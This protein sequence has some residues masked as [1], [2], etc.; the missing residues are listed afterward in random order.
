[1]GEGELQK[2]RSGELELLYKD[3]LDNIRLYKQQQFAITN[4]VI[5]LYGAIVALHERLLGGVVEPTCLE[6]SVL[7]SVSVLVLIVGSYLI[8][9]FH[10]NMVGCRK[11]MEKIR[12]SFEDL[13]KE[14]WNADAKPD[15][16]S[17]LHNIGVAITL[18]GILVLGMLAVWWT[19]FR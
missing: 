19:I 11:R 13:S 2:K 8:I 7:A 18:V 10:C 12:E 17:C 15:H 5:L 1:M 4:Y 9:Q 14:A 6:K 3:A 16:A